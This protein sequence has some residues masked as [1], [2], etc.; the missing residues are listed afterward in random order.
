MIIRIVLSA[1]D[2]KGYLKFWQTD[3]KGTILVLVMY[4]GVK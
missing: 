3:L 2:A 1:F 4:N